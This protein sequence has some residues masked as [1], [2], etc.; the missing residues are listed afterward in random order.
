MPGKRKSDDMDSPEPQEKL[1]KKA[2]L[3]LAR[4]RAARFAKRDKEKIEKRKGKK[5]S[6]A[7]SKVGHQ[8]KSQQ[9]QVE[10]SYDETMTTTSG[11]KKS[12][13]KKPTLTERKKIAMEN[14]KNFAAR[15]KAGLESRKNPP[16]NF[17]AARKQK[18]EA[19]AAE[20]AS[21]MEGV[22]YTQPPRTQNN[23]STVIDPTK[24]EAYEKLRQMQ[25]A[26]LQQQ[27]VVAQQLTQDATAALTQQP[28][29]PSVDVAVP[30]QSTAS[31]ETVPPPSLPPDRSTFE[32]KHHNSLSLQRD[33]DNS[34]DFEDVNEKD[35]PPPPPALMAQVSQQVLLN[36]QNEGIDDVDPISSESNKQKEENEFQ[37]TA[38]CSNGVH[39]CVEETKGKSGWISKLTSVAV[40][41]VAIVSVSIMLPTSLIEDSRSMEDLATP[42]II[43]CFFDSGSEYDGCPDDSGGMECPEG[44]IC[45]GGKLVDCVNNL[46]DVSEEG[47]KCILGEEYIVMKTAIMNQLVNHAS[48][49]CDQSATP[50]FKYAMLQKD[51]PDIPEDET[52]D[53]IDALTNEGFVVHEREGLYVGLPEGFEVTLPMYCV[54]GNAGQWVLQE[55]GLLIL[56]FLRFAFFNFY[57]FVLAY[58]KLSAL[59][60]A[61]LGCFIWYRRRRAAKM[62]LQ[63]DISRTREIAYRTL[64]ES[65][66]VQHCAIHIRDEIA[67]ALYPNSKTL[68]LHLQKTVWPKIVDDVKRDTRVRKFQ[69]FSKT[70]LTRDMWQWTA[71]SKTP[72]QTSD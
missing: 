3:K 25:C 9:K 12:P 58:P 60:T 20:D 29:I 7:K 67:M 64:E 23:F 72:N 56:G 19:E 65:C 55:V 37:D 5:N 16:R 54:L 50:S 45:Q 18:P 71:A 34:Y 39:K 38:D 1:S 26:M 2:K 44:G 68:R 15:D 21:P 28:G 48:Q 59:N 51:Q 32:G 62:K 33:T 63:E 40:V 27:Q 35:I 43:P 70:G 53:L 61:I 36:V 13:K 47:D 22:E 31:R 4:E 69:T 6:P 8:T 24:V 52:E 17:D 41:G 66:G 11:A 10:E 46:L 49:I 42:K 30:L 14:A 57:G